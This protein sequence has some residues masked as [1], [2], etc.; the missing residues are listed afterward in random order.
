MNRKTPDISP[1]PIPNGEE[2]VLG[3]HSS[4]EIR[5]QKALL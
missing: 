3:A 1:I 4:R 5:R 2:V